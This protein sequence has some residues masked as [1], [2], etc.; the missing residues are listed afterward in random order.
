MGMVQHC[1][2]GDDDVGIACNWFSDSPLCFGC[3]LGARV[4]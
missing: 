4:F 3:K 2:S 1:A